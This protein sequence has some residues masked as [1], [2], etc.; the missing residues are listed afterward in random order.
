MKVLIAY[1]PVLHRGYEDFFARHADAEALL[2]FGPETIS[3]FEWLKKDLRC[4]DPQLVV[5]AVRSWDVFPR[6]TFL[7]HATVELIESATLLVMPDETECRM[8]AESVFPGMR[9]QFDSVKLRYDK[10]KTESTED[11]QAVEVFHEEMLAH[12]N[13]IQD[14]A[15]RNSPDWWIRVGGMIVKDGEPILTAWNEHKPSEREALFMGDPRSNYKRGLNIELSLA[16]HAEKVLVGE[17]ARRGI[18]LEGC[19]LLVTTFPCPPCARLVA[20]AGIK[21]VF[22]REG[23]SVLEG[24]DL[25]RK[26]K[27]EIFR[28]KKGS[29]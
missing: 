2:I 23:Y 1:V 14:L 16:D 13:L 27:V 18:A 20:R 4:L 7:E 3:R 8:V 28:V 5:E 10:K 12:M 29:Q 15:D 22:F 25:F 17:A 21:R 6:V 26:E 9:V 19:D 24:E 11:I